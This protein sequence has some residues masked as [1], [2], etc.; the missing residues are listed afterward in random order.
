MRVIE[1]ESPLPCWAVRLVLSQ[2]SKPLDSCHSEFFLGAMLSLFYIVILS[3]VYVILSLFYFVILREHS[4]RRISKSSDHRF[5][6]RPFTLSCLPCILNYKRR[7]IRQWWMRRF[8]QQFPPHRARVRQ[9]LML[10]LGI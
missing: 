5:S 7:F 1:T 8:T 10:L 3:L 6:P 2:S 4:D 9:P